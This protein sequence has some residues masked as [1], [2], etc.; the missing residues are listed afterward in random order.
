MQDTHLDGL[1]SPRGGQPGSRHRQRGAGQGKVFQCGSAFHEGLRPRERLKRSGHM[2][3][4]CCCMHID[5]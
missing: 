4:A 2:A 1:L 3:G 5:C